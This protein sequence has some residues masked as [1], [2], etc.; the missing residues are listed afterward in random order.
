MYITEASLLA[1]VVAEA[2]ALH[3]RKRGFWRGLGSGHAAAKLRLLMLELSFFRSLFLER[4]G[5]VYARNGAQNGALFAVIS[6]CF[7]KTRI[8]DFWGTSHAIASNMR[9]WRLPNPSWKHAKMRCDF[10]C[11]FGMFFYGFWWTRV[12]RNRTG[13]SFFQ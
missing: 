10:E 6:L 3:C 4:P 2:S 13:G 8:F 5:R 9:V 12:S 1:N 7:Q 11:S